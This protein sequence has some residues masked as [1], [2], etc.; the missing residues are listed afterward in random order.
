MGTGKAA[1]VPF[2][3]LDS[4][5][6]RA[7]PCWGLRVCALDQRR[8]A[9]SQIVNFSGSHSSQAKDTDEIDFS[10]ISYLTH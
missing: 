9:Q 2:E 8:P 5:W 1:S 7:A 6:L 10:S 4:L 3:G